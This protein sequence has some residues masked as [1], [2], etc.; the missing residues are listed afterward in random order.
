MSRKQK[1]I[2]NLQSFKHLKKNW[3]YYGAEPI[4]N[5]LI[6]KCIGYINGLD[7]QYQ[8]EVFPTGRQ[9]I[10]FE[11]ETETKYLELEVMGDL[12]ECLLVINDDL[13]F[14]GYVSSWDCAVH[15]IETFYELDKQE[16]INNFCD[17]LI[18]SQEEMPTDY[19]DLVNKNL[20]D[21]I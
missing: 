1:N 16:I 9:T 5:D 8:P 10:Q 19:V 17:K 2:T 15:L 6:D 21:L 4:P 11:W 7:E 20:W 12:I 14:A 13:E 3:N 18:S